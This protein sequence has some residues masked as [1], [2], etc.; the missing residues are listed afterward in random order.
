MPSRSKTE[1]RIG[2]NA[3][4]MA[5]AGHTCLMENRDRQFYFMRAVKDSTKESPLALPPQ[6]IPIT[7]PPHRIVNGTQHPTFHPTKSTTTTTNHHDRWHTALDELFLRKSSPR[8]PTISTLRD[9]GGCKLESPFV[10]SLGPRP[11]RHAYHEHRNSTDRRERQTIDD[12]RTVDDSQMGKRSER[13]DGGCLNGVF[14]EEHQPANQPTPV[15]AQC[16]HKQH[17]MASAITAVRWFAWFQIYQGRS[18][19]IY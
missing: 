13:I 1:H 12:V 17:G 2:G 4:A 9:P 19:F 3:Q 11:R 16:R 18:D 8:S 10:I 5:G 6:V 14:I 15:G 7:P